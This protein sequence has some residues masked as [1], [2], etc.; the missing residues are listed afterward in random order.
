[1]FKIYFSDQCY[2]GNTFGMYPRVDD[3]D[4]SNTCSDDNDEYCGGNWRNSI[5]KI[6]C[7]HF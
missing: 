6:I 5:Y 7:I 3:S 4:C 2:C 1:M